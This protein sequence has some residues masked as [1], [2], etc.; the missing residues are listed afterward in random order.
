MYMVEARLPALQ[1]VTQHV[2]PAGGD[3]ACLPCR[4]WR[5]R[6]AAPPPAGQSVTK[7][8]FKDQIFALAKQFHNVKRLLGLK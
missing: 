1:V 4:L 8:D 7:P 3:A 6:H 2:C 5:G